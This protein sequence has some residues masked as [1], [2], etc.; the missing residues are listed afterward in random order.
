MNFL[1]PFEQLVS[2]PSSRAASSSAS[3]CM[4]RCGNG[5]Y[6][7]HSATAGQYGNRSGNPWDKLAARV[8]QATTEDGS[9]AWFRSLD[10]H[11]DPALDRYT[12]AGTG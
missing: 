1:I 11:P 7:G 6:H 9:S 4:T 8:D 12:R 2:Q 5:V 3:T 10:H